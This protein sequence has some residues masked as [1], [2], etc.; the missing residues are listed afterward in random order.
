MG[1][2]SKAERGYGDD[3]ERDLP[4]SNTRVEELSNKCSGRDGMAD[5]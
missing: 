4:L 5:G 3:M 1:T 2:K